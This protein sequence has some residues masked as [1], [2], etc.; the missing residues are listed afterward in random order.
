MVQH[1]LASINPYK[2]QG[3]DSLH[4]AV[5]EAIATL[6]A[7]PLIDL[8]SLSLVSAEAPDDW[9]SAIVCS[10]FKKGDREDPGYYCPVSFTS[11]V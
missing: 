10:I 7:Q 8:L 4:P 3:P 2:G 1:A 9:R 11:I 5:L 6:V